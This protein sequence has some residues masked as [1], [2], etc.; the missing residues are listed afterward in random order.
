MPKGLL[1]GTSQKWP[2]PQKRNSQA[3]DAHLIS[4]NPATRKVEVS[5]CIKSPD[6]LSLHGKSV[7]DEV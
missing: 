6:Y 4:I 5:D 7:A 1:T 3:F 2:S